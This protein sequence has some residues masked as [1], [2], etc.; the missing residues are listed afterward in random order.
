MILDAKLNFQEH[1][2]N[3]L[4]KVNKTIGLLQKLQN[5]L[6]RGSLRTIFKSFVRPQLDYGDVV[7][8]QSFN[9]TFHQKMESFQYN[10][11]LAIT[12]AIRDS[13]REKL[14]QEL[15][16]ESLQQRRWYKKLCCFFKLIKKKSPKYLFNNIST[17]RSTYRTR[18]IGNIPQFNVS[19]SRN[20]YFPSIVTEW[21]N[22]GKSIRNSESFSVFKKNILQF[23][24]P[25]PNST[26]NC[27]NPQGVKLLTRLRIGLSHLRDH[28]FKHSFQDFLNPICNFETDVERTTHYTL[29]CPLF[30]D[31]RLILIN[32]IRNIGN[33]ILNLNDSRFSEVLLFGNSSF[34]NTKNT[35]ILNTTIEYIVSS[36]RSEVPLFDSS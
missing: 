27:H 32:N 25:S 12:G 29:H 1:I 36:K 35:S 3:L 15:G 28:K 4:T 33:N 8:D 9:N 20:S 11:A 13:S 7:Y 5:I 6:P 22:L 18:N 10:A 16:L 34:N 2:K 30:S 31:E 17:V 19:F 24:R 26:F 14:Y 21:N 23:I